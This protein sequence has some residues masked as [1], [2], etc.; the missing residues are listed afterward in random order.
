[1]KDFLEQVEEARAHKRGIESALKKFLAGTVIIGAAVI[2][3]GFYDG[4]QVRVETVYTVQPGDT[5]WSISEE[6]LQKNTGGRRY[7][8]EFMSGIREVNPWLLETKDQVHPG[9]KVTIS[10]WIKKSEVENR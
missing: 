1:M 9:D 4:D 8:L 7:I 3:A 6:Y 10:Y 5:L 2:C